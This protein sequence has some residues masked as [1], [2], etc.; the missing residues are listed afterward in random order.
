MFNVKPL[1]FALL[2][3]AAVPAHADWYLDNESSRLSF[4]T[5]K[6]TEVAE[7]QRFLV[8]HGKVDA[9]G[10]A[11]LEVELDS[12]NSGIPLRDER[13]RKE[14]FEIKTFPEAQISAQINLQPINDLASG[15][16]LELR[17]PLSVTLHG[18]TQTYSAELL[19]TRLDERRFQ[20][21]TLEPVVLH[22]EDFD[23]A[24]GV[25]TLRKAAGLKSI[26]LSVPVGAVLIFTA[27]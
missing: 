24:P 5:T 22:A 7:V 10:A 8:L 20:V 17:L 25:A 26:S 23:L 1:V 16:Q 21:V 18:K 3:C 2:T 27:R 12:I 13:M 4:V 11:R 14:L 19:A 15:A 9:K 6:N